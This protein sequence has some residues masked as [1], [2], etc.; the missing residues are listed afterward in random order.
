MKQHLNLTMTEN[1]AQPGKE[2][3]TL[4]VDRLQQDVRAHGLGPPSSLW[5]ACFTTSPCLH[6]SSAA[7]ATTRAT[8]RRVASSRGV[9]RQAGWSPTA[10]VKPSPPCVA[11]GTTPPT[12]TGWRWV[13]PTPMEGCCHGLLCCNAPLASAGRLH[14]Q[15]GAVSGRSPPGHRSG[16]D[17]RGMPAGKTRTCQPSEARACFSFF[18]SIVLLNCVYVRVALVSCLLDLSEP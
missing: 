3:I 4:A 11:G 8:G 1:Y 13:P 10:A 7:A 14:L 2:D 18:R 15:A 16:G 6:S 9:K 12:S 17:R 5:T